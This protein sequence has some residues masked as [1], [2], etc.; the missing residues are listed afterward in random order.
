M[1]IR[2]EIEALNEGFARDLAAQDVEGLVARYTDDAQFLFAGQPILRGREAVETIMREW[3]ADGPVKVRFESHEVMTDGSL[4]VDVGVIVGPS[5]PTTKYVVVYRRQPD[6]RL[7]IAIDS[8]SG[9]G[10]APAEEA[11]T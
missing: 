2:E 9:L 4:A 11:A 7:R 5:G 1:T 8:A 6:G 3:V 10:A